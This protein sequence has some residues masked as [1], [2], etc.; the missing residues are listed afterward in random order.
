EAYYQETGRAGRDGEAA[1]A[2]MAYGMQDIIQLRQWIAQSEG[3]DAFKQIQRQ[4][5]DALIGLAEMAGCR[6]QALLA[7]FGERLTAPC[8]N[9]DNCLTPPATVDGTVLAQKAL[10]A[11]YRTGQR[12]G[13]GYV[14]D[15]LAGKTNER[16]IRNSHD[17][18][19]VF[20]IGADADAATWRALFRQLTAAGH[21]AGDEDGHGTL[22]L[23]ESA[24][25]ILRGERTFPMRIAP[26]IEKKEKSRRPAKGAGNRSANV[27]AGDAALYEALRA[28]R[29]ELAARAKVPPYVICHDRTLVELATVKPTS[30]AGLHDIT[31]L[32]AAKI[33]RYG[34]EM[35][36]VIGASGSAPRDQRLDNRLSSTVNQTLALHF[37]GLDADEIAQRRGIERSTVLGHLADAIEAG[38]I[39]AKSAVGL[40]AAEIEEIVDAF[41]RC[42]T[43]ESGK[44]GPAHAT[45]GGR[46]DFG[47]LKCLLAELA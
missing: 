39:D 21:L 6:R 22:L 40:D 4:K 14:L 3:S 12:Y 37:A 1:D 47:T 38:L 31:G 45:L 33:A 20:G 36:A 41:E 18:L 26:R 29:L 23:T 24:R 7:Y 44:L 43:L 30:E 46:F 16:I 42:G 5:L 15:I 28:L 10:S 9:C 11:V 19:S 17:R 13:V 25:P 27:A 35:L 2:W 32:G 34:S 8:G